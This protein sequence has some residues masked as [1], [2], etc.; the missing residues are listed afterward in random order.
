MNCAQ[1]QL[2]GNWVPSGKGMRMAA[3][4]LFFEPV[5]MRDPFLP[6]PDA[7]KLRGN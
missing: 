1:Q 5:C 4:T 3:G 7:G 2:K 6:E